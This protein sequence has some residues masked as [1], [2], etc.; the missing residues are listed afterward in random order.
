[1]IQTYFVKLRGVNDRVGVNFVTKVLD[2]F[3]FM[4]ML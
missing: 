1:M 3:N 2:L 4:T